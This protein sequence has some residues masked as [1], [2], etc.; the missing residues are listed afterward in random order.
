MDFTSTTIIDLARRVRS[1]EL[2]ARD[3]VSHALTT[4][5]ARNGD[6]KAFVCVDPEGAL[7]SA[8]AIDDAVARGEASGLP[9]AGIPFGVKDLEDARGM[10]TRRG[11]ALSD[12]TPAS[13]DSP[14]VAALRAAGAIPVGKTNTPEDGHTA[15]TDNA[16][17]GRTGNPA[18]PGRSPGGSSGGSA[19]AIAAGM[20]PLATGS[21]GGG[22]IRIPASLCGLSGLKPTQ[23]VVPAGPLPP[24]ANLLSTRG[25]MTRTAAE[26]ALALSVMA[27]GDPSIDP[28]GA[29]TLDPTALA[30][31]A[32]GD[33]KGVGGRDRPLRVVWVPGGGTDVD[34]TVDTVTN[35]AV[36]HLAAAGVEVEVRTTL[37]AEDP[38]GAWWTLWTAAMAARHGHLRGTPEWDLLWPGVQDLVAWGLDRVSGADTTRAL[39]G[40]WHANA[41]VTAAL[42]DAD[43]LLLPTI[44]GR[45]PEA[46]SLGTINGEETPMWVRFTYPFNLT[47]HPAG[48]VCA[49]HDPDGL[50]VGL[51][52]VGRHHDDATVLAVMSLCET[53][54]AE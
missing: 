11:S 20:V 37:F 19:A 54:L 33:P 45:V 53:V 23:G 5:E 17:T 22:S 12:V 34:P 24:G 6:L 2:S 38:L 16:V 51:Q 18:H 13:A 48:S 29:P 3:L 49:G 52:I 40:I 31:L 1:G 41:D 36:A 10:P 47:R 39:D 30:A 25:P 32:D 46:G 7:Q 50:P 4:I 21:D 9:L 14:T 44:A 27:D 15:D 28:F 26:A 42:G 43:V 35:A 8:A